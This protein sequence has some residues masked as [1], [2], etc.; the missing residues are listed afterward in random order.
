MDKH[1]LNPLIAAAAQAVQAASGLTQAQLAL[2]LGLD[3]PRLSVLLNHRRDS[4][5]LADQIAL[6]ERA[7]GVPAG[8]INRLVY[9]ELEVA[10]LPGLVD[11]TP[12]HLFENLAHAAARVEVLQQATEG[13]TEGEAA[14]LLLNEAEAHLEAANMALKLWL[15]PTVDHALAADTGDRPTAH[16]KG[17]STPRRGAAPAEQE[18]Y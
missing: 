10:A 12:R 7:A 18:D 3:Q 9:G 16:P 5:F 2:A 1:S 17:S 15:D 8:T 6:F 14:A 13:S 4:R 11:D